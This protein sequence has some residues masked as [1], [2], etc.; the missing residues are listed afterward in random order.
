MK[1]L[2]QMH[3]DYMKANTKPPTL[4]VIN[5]DEFMEFVKQIEEFGPH[6]IPSDMPIHV[7]PDQQSHYTR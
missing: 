3:I 5:T 2:S 4:L 6:I 1:N 7:T